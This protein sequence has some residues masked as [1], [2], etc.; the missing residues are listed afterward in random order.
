MTSFQT[1]PYL[2]LIIYKCQGVTG[3]LGGEG[4]GLNHGGSVQYK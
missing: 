1:A 3:K 4:W 2:P